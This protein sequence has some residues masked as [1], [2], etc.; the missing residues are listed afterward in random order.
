MQSQFVGIC[1]CFLFLSMNLMGQSFPDTAFLQPVSVK[2]TFVDDTQADRGDRLLVDRDNN[3]YVLK[4]N[5]L[6][7]LLAGKLVKNRQYRPLQHKIPVDVAVQSPTKELYYLYNDRFLSNTH[8]GK[9]YGKFGS[10]QF[11]KMAVNN[12]GA[13]LLAG[14][15][16]FQLVKEESST[17]GRESDAIEEV[18]AYE[19]DFYIKTRF[20]INRYQD[21]R[22]EPVITDSKITA[23]AFD[24]DL[25][26]VANE[27]GFYVV[28]RANGRTISPLQNKLPVLPAVS[29]AVH[30]GVVWMGSDHGVYSTTDGNNFRYYAS[31]RWLWEDVVYDV[32]HDSDGNAYVLTSSGVSKI[33][34]KPMTLADKAAYFL[35]E[36]RKRHLRYGL[37]G[38]VHFK[39]PGDVTTMEMV[40]T[41]NDGLWTSFYLGSE[42]FR[43]A[44]TGESQAR[45]NA[46]E[47]F[48]AFER[49]LSIN[50]LEGFP[51]RT[52][53]RAGYKVS[54]PDRWRDSPEE[55]W[56]WKG[57]TSSDE[58]V[59]YIW[60]AGIMHQ[61]LDLNPQEHQRV[62]NF[63]D[64]IMMHIIRNDYYLVD[65]DEKPTLWGRWN[66]TYINS[67]PKSVVDRKLGSTTITAGLQLAH[68]LTGKDIYTTER[69]RLFEE[70]GYLENIKIPVAHIQSTPNVFYKGHNMGEGG[71]NHSDDEMAFL[72][73]WILYHFAPNS[74]LKTIYADVISDHWAIEKPERNAL[75]SVIAYGTSGDIDVES[76]KWHLQ[77]YPLDQ[78]RWTMKNSHRK[79]L[80]FLESNFREQSTKTLISPAE[81]HA[82]RHNSNPFDLDGG[83]NGMTQLAG[84]EYLL[85]YW[86]GRYLQVIVPESSE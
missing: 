5:G 36:T 27:S 42:V 57:H 70:H 18:K 85:P 66:P 77:E 8:A 82:I 23:W 15:H 52:F 24:K 38:E 39:K 7:I 10:G 35:D 22:F 68:A 20:G 62:A 33:D 69:E 25:L 3:V 40:D 28:D 83:R 13:V 48:E 75:W 53:E 86:M 51:S 81:R 43:Y 58:F 59:A 55:G 54:D 32:T 78:I 44:T 71:W 30:Q 41:D 26:Y 34:F 9:P 61:Y 2:Y 4:E 73:Y 63:I 1:I 14:D 84:D 47:S 79:D 67:Y 21:G 60:V 6:Y 50:E 17:T 64:A 19:E 72:T 45:S 74:E 37:I 12:S 56:E 31:K 49:L 76:V 11:S 80:E 29:M 46:M 16:G 65:V